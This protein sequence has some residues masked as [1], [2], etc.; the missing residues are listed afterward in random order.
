MPV[1]SPR[2]GRGFESRLPFHGTGYSAKPQL[3]AGVFCFMTYFVYIIESALDGTFYIGVS[4]DPEKRLEKHKFLH[5]EHSA[6][7]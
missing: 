6:G 4:S 3:K 7:K 2:E 1:P 5:I